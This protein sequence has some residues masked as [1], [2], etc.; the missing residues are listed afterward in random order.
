MILNIFAVKYR[1]VAYNNRMY[2]NYRFVDNKKYS[3][4]DAKL[5]IENNGNRSRYLYDLYD[6]KKN[7]LFYNYEDMIDEY[8]IVRDMINS[9]ENNGNH[10]DSIKNIIFN[11]K[12]KWEIKHTVKTPQMYFEDLMT[13]YNEKINIY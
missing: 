9:T 7:E 13:I 2:K 8:R 11:F 5:W 6:T 1:I 10:V 4:I 12:N 3:F